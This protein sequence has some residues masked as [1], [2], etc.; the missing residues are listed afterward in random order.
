MSSKLA[1]LCGALLLTSCLVDE[2]DARCSKN[3]RASGNT[4]VCVEGTVATPGK[5]GCEPCGD[6]EEAVGGK[7]NCVEGYKR[8]TKGE[9]FMQAVGLGAECSDAESCID[10][11]PMCVPGKAAKFCTKSCEAHA[12]CGSGWG[13]EKVGEQRYCTPEP[14]GQAMPCDTSADCEGFDASYCSVTKACVV[15]NCSKDRPCHGPWACCDFASYGAPP[16]CVPPEALVND[17]CPVGVPKLD[18]EP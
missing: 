16:V 13:C 17:A 5:A 6:H 15:S 8:N 12:D 18:S 14:T 4:C 9:C 10:E 2:G 11:F 7:C 1:W 3:Q